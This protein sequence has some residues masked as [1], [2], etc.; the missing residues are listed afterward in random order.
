MRVPHSTVLLARRL[1]L[2]GV[3]VLDLEFRGWCGLLWLVW[4]HNNL[5]LHTLLLLVAAAAAAAAA[6]AVA[7]SAVVAV[8]VAAASAAAAAAV[9]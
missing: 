2:L 8:A 9:C 3:Q 7:A 4:V 5:V 1:L 6:S